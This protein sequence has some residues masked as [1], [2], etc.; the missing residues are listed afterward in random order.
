[1]SRFI[2]TIVLILLMLGG[3]TAGTIK[4]PTDYATIQAG[5]DAAVN[6]DTVLVAEGTYY[7]NI[8]FKGK[9]IIVAS[10][11]LVDGD[12]T[13]I[14]NTIIDGSRPS[15]PNK[16]SVVSFTSGE[17]TT[18]IICGFTITGGTGTIAG[19]NSRVGG[20]IYCYSSAA[21]IANNKIT[22]NK[23]T[24]ASYARGGGIGTFPF[25]NDCY[26]IVENSIISSNSCIGGTEIKHNIIRENSCQGLDAMGGG[27]QSASDQVVQRMVYVTQNTIVNN[28]CI[29]SGE[30]GMGGGVDIIWCKFELVA[31][32][33]THNK[34]DGAKWLLGGGIRIW[35]IEAG[36]VKDN[37]ISF[38]SVINGQEW[39]YGGGID[40]AHCSSIIVQGNRFEGNKSDEGGGM[41][42]GHNT[43]C[44]VSFNE[45]IANT[46]DWGGGLCEWDNTQHS[47]MNNLF[48]QNTAHLGGG[49]YWTAD[50]D[51]LFTN[52]ILTKNVSRRGGGA[53]FE[54][55]EYFEVPL[56]ARVI[57]NTFTENVA[58]TAGGIF[59][60]DY[61][62]VAMNNICWGNNALF[63]QEILVHGGELNVA[64]SDIKGGI[65]NIVTEE[66]GKVNWLAGNID[67]NPLFAF[68]DHQLSNSSPC[69]GAGAEMIQIE[70]NNYEC[71][72]SDIEGNLRPDPPGSMPDIGA[73][74]NPLDAH[75]GPI[76]VPE[77]Y[78]SIQAGIDAASDGN[79]V[80]VADGTYFENINFKG[81][82]IT[83]ASHY[84]MD[85][86]T[87]HI[88][89]TIIDGSQPSHADSGS[90]VFF[91]SG[92]DTTSVLCGFT[93]TNGSGTETTFWY[94]STQYFY[95]AGGGIFCYNSGTRLVNNKIINNTVVS[96]D[97]RVLGGGLAAPLYGS[98]AYLILQDN[99]I[100]NNTITANANH[101]YGGGVAFRGEGTL[102]NNT[103]S[104]NSVIQNAT[105][106]QAGSG[107]ID[108]FGCLN[109]IMESN[110]IT[111]NSVV[112]Y[113]NFQ[114]TAVAGGCMI[115]HSQGRFTKNKVSHNEIWVKSDKNGCGAG[116]LFEHV[117]DSFIIE[118]NIIRENAVK[119]GYGFGGGVN[120]AANSSATVINN[121]IE[122]NSATNGGGFLITENSVAKLI[123]NTI[124]NNLA[125][126]GGGICLGRIS[127]HT[128][129]MN[130]I[131]WGNQAS[132][133]PAIHIHTGTI[134]VAYSDIQGGWPG[135]GNINADPLFADTLFHLSDD[136][137]CIGAGV[138]SHDF[139]SGMMCYCPGTDIAGSYRPNPIGST[140]DIGAYESWLDKP[141]K[142]SDLPV[143]E[144]PQSYFLAQNY[145]NPFNPATTIEFAL[146]QSAFVTLK[147]YNLLGEEIT[148]LI[149][150]QRSAGIY[151]L[152]WDASGLASGV[153]LYR[154]EACHPS[155]GSGQVFVQT[156]KLILMR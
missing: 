149:A 63:A 89:N 54:D 88:N 46:A 148:T 50:C 5:I 65:A 35:G 23:I 52:N 126:F 143:T 97:R 74:E 71:P 137:P 38:N 155:I 135:T 14:N 41:V 146:P 96:P 61:K 81:K 39:C 36:L 93:I 150:E 44:V 66:A 124:I 55:S 99:Q 154:L 138:H 111:H 79:M 80:L 115:W 91:I 142:V 76:R 51:M 86:D 136:S 134:D 25:G 156:K 19:D 45:F 20:G 141:I 47:V 30:L 119:R 58:D 122:G 73:Y 53:D 11:F 31:N 77:Q 29:C 40:V 16:G 28:Q 133:N 139:G 62:V 106:K 33:I 105:D 85:G 15:D 43:S 147:V 125:T 100:M 8:N 102:I 130:T 144:I 131:I 26:T 90:V 32:T 121:I 152:N 117:L 116:V 57:N 128:Y 127:S 72:N 95:R 103:I 98:T 107:G 60:W 24:Y 3:V 151:K 87:T 101:I 21:R 42:D 112:S 84:L 9:A 1:M 109:L 113:S 132:T 67:A 17:D 83:V 6:G 108:I 49:G 7:E 56:N 48:L 18:S 104:F 12:T 140:P 114:V 10:Q 69:I 68:P 37:I 64:Y 129:L 27:I 92:E 75:I 59:M 110:E 2:F 4:V 82:A 94:D 153:Y 120:I 22:N 145:P 123:N 78:A 118:G 13:H 70:G 34:I